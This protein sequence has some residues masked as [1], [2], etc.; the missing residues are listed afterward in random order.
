MVVGRRAAGGGPRT[1]VNR[2]LCPFLPLAEDLSDVRLLRHEHVEVLLPLFLILNLDLLALGCSRAF[3]RHPQGDVRLAGGA[4]QLTHCEDRVADDND[5]LPRL[6]H[7]PLETKGLQLEGMFLRPLLLCG[8][9][10]LGRRNGAVHDPREGDRDHHEGDRV[11]HLALL[12]GEGDC[13]HQEDRESSRDHLSH[14]EA[15][16]PAPELVDI[17][18]EPHPLAG[19][20]A[21]GEG[22][23]HV[24]GHGGQQNGEEVLDPRIEE[25]LGV[26][27]LGH[28][29]DADQDTD[30]DGRH[31]DHDREVECSRG[32]P[33]EQNQDRVEHSSH[34]QG[35]G[36]LRPQGLEGRKLVPATLLLLAEEVQHSPVQGRMNPDDQTQHLEG[37]LGHD[38]IERRKDEHPDEA[39][40]TRGVE[41]RNRRGHVARDPE[42]HEERH[43][44]PV[45]EQ[46]GGDPVP[47]NVHE[48]LAGPVDPEPVEAARQQAARHE[49]GPHAAVV[50]GGVGLDHG[51]ARVYQ[52]LE[53]S[54]VLLGR[55]HERDH[56]DHA[57]E[58]AV[59][60]G[61][62]GLHGEAV[63]DVHVQGCPCEAA[64]P[65]AV[66]REDLPDG[67]LV[68]LL[69]QGL[70]HGIRQ[71][72]AAGLDRPPGDRGV[73]DHGLVGRSQ[74]SHA[75]LGVR[76]TGELGEVGEEPVEEALHGLLQNGIREVL[77][78]RDPALQN[79]ERRLAD[80]GRQRRPRQPE[81]SENLI[82]HHRHQ[83]GDD[84]GVRQALTCRVTD[85]L[86][87]H[88]L[89][90]LPKW[91]GRGR[92]LLGCHIWLLPCWVS[93]TL[94]RFNFRERFNTAEAAA[95]PKE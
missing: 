95:I 10:A 29:P 63:L 86:A 61:H 31:Q 73:R 94:S 82:V 62:P 19:E 64:H 28:V 56:G 49:R 11:P 33:Q 87:D 80:A 81:R 89:H 13:G 79:L 23:V 54:L 39:P 47:E 92:G 67:V 90:R 83:E 9:G 26:A 57:R 38:Q 66:P 6:R 4:T 84:V 76:R 45:L 50:G 93:R 36:G 68:V 88:V 20:L 7:L 16:R 58:I 40:R 74:Q 30:R 44:L 14:A 70:E 77:E 22:V 60:E 25:E 72:E 8:L 53:G 3:A 51:R 65:V 42:G 12:E 5:G 35:A 18:H 46:S 59:V 71:H 43:E 1:V 41:P 85:L 17:A 15:G 48:V 27:R 37:E 69:L 34:Q 21:L 55:L 91:N 32:L 78:D 75:R 24:P 2:T 52:V